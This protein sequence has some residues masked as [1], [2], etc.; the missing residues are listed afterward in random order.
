[1]DTFE[2]VRHGVTRRQFLTLAAGTTAAVVIPFLPAYAAVPRGD[3]VP[4]NLKT[5]SACNPLGV[6]V[7]GPRLSW[8]LS[9]RERGARQGAYRVLVATSQIQLA[10][11]RADVWDSGRVNSASSVDIDYAGPPLQARQRYYWKVQVWNQDGRRSAWSDPAGWEMGLMSPDDWTGRWIGRGAQEASAGESPAPLLRREFTLDKPVRHARVYVAGVGYHELELNGQRVGDHV[12][13]PACT[14]YDK[15]VLYVTH[16]VTDMLKPGRNALGA[17]LGRGFFGLRTSTAW[18]WTKAA[19]H[20]DPRLL[21][22]LEVTYIDGTRLVVATDMDWRTTDGPTRFD[23]LYA[24]ETYDARAVQPGWSQLDFHDDNWLP[25]M[26]MDPPRGRLVA[27]SMEP[28]R[29]LETVDAVSISEPR[30]G[31]YVFD[32]GRTLGGW[33]HLRVDGERG[34]RIILKYA[35]QLKADG[36]VNLDQGYVHGGRFQ[37]DE[38]V[39]R[40][41]GIETWHARFSHKSFRYIEVTGLDHAPGLAMLRGQE[42]RS[43]VRATGGFSSSSYLYNQIHAMV[44]RSVGHHLLGIPAVDVMYEK[45]GWTAD[46]QLNTPSMAINYDTHRFL[47]KWLDDFADSQTTEGGI[48]LIVPSGGWGYD[49]QGPEW[50]AAYPIV[51]WE[52]Y[53]RFG[54]RRALADHYDGVRRYVEWEM[55]R[56]DPSGLATTDLGDWLAPGG[57]TQPPEDSRLTATAYLYRDL[58]I[59]ASSAAVLGRAADIPGLKKQASELRERFNITFLDRNRG[60]YRTRTDPGYRQC[61]NAI[62]LAFG[63]APPEFGQRVAD[64]LAADVR[65]RGDH[66]NTGALG[67]AVL[68]P[69]LTDAGY[70]DVAH[71]IA[72]QR[73]FPSWGFWLAN[74][75]DTLWETWELQQTGQGRPPSHDHYLFGSIDPWFYE[76]IAGITPAAPAYERI[77]IEP[78][79]DGPL[80]WAS[81]WMDTVRGRVTVHWKKIPE[82]GLELTVDI[83]ANATADIRLPVKAGDTVLEGGLPPVKERGIEPLGGS[84]YRVGSGH[85]VFTASS[86][87]GQRGA[88][89]DPR[90]H[91]DKT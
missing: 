39:L 8:Q 41:G 46:A 54:D 23:S 32:M 26:A 21:L 33:A 76:Q 87:Q 68:L 50:K 7:P 53:R 42:V 4:G 84:A 81:A 86:N 73:T 66:L 28:I 44:N 47:A 17:E 25:V 59:L 61:S 22:Q 74:G 29:E 3:L 77:G 89:A 15:R 71:A 24:G 11:D 27:Q 37:T 64:Q 6:D 63:L 35:Q 49:A 13:D 1:M 48:P 80:Q 69:V 10:Q 14:D 57:Y 12:L 38:Y 16:D 52:L 45:I 90:Q 34:A 82:G 19:W 43:S 58:Q 2:L 30:P 40:G 91:P 5:E 18:A 62:A 36:T 85:Y 56:L 31:V 55:G 88:V 60:I 65:A 78:F 20:G 67:T 9:S 51:M 83:P 79:I 75:A 70:V 72:G